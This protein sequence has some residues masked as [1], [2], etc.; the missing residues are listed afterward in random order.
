[1]AK[2]RQS[3]GEHE[4]GH[5]DTHGTPLAAID[6]AWEVM[7]G[8]DWD[9]CG[10]PK[11]PLFARLT[12]LLPIYEDI[13]PSFHPRVV[14]HGCVIYGDSL[15]VSERGDWRASHRKLINAPWSDLQ[16]WVDLLPL[17]SSPFAWVGPSRTNARWFQDLTRV[18]DVIWFPCNR[19]TY[20]GSKIQP[21]FHSCMAFRGVDHLALRAA[22]PRHFPKDV[23]PCLYPTRY[24]R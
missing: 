12:T 9:P 8:I 10:N 16:P 18:A 20:A 23:D 6:L 7:G 5:D 22:I 19:F 13:E 2:K 4:Q 1:M 24:L 21:P 17:S 15:A 11:N 14:E 3:G